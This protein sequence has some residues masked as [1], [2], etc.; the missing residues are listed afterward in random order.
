MIKCVTKAMKCRF[1]KS[2]SLLKSKRQIVVTHLFIACHPKVS[3]REP[4]FYHA[5]VRAHGGGA[6]Q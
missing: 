4:N 2:N 1:P 3:E 6:P 5:R